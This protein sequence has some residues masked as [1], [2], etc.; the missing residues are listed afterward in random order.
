M[1]KNSSRDQLG[2]VEKT[3]LFHLN[4]ARQTQYEHRVSELLSQVKV[5]SNIRHSPLS[6]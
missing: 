1:E 6:D 4:S 5:N 3:I 2:W